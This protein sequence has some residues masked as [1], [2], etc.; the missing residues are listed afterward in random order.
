MVIYKFF[1]YSCQFCKQSA[2]QLTTILKD[3]NQ[4]FKII[5]TPLSFGNEFSP[6][7]RAASISACEYDSFGELSAHH[8]FYNHQENLEVALDSG[9][10]TILHRN[11]D[12]EIDIIQNCMDSPLY[13]E[14]L[15]TNRSI[16][17]Q[18]GLS[19]VP[20]LLIDTDIYIGTYSGRQLQSIINSY[21][22]DDN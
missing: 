4:K 8:F 15:E 10:T 18:V 19:S 17:Q 2:E 3:F 22:T 1:D 14:W 20:A 12:D 16:A 5:H 6:N 9:L 11:S 13:S 21:L 7:H